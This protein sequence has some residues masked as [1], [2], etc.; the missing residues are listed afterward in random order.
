MMKETVRFRFSSVLAAIV[1]YWAVTPLLQGF[2]GLVVLTD[3]FF[4]AVLI[5]AIWA[6]AQIPRQAA[7]AAGLALPM[8]VSLWL[9]HFGPRPVLL[10]IGSVFEVLFFG[11]TAWLILSAVIKAP[12]ISREIIAA[13]IVV[14]MFLGLIWAGLYSVLELLQPGSFLIHGAVAGPT[15]RH[16]AYFSYT[17]L[18]TLGY[19]DITP[20]SGS[21]RALSTLEALIGQIYLA[22]LIARLVG[23][24]A[25]QGSGE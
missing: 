12:A 7:V 8:L 11:Y 19:G 2:F 1:V 20:I 23:I 10:L 21:A 5:S 13:A 17:T 15:S 18:T 24:H 9:L 4:S 14:Y 16:F 25:A 22:V 3:L 6:V